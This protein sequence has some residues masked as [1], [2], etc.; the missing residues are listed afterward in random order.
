M[1]RIKHM[2]E[3]NDTLE[4]G[5][6][7]EEPDFVVMQSTIPVEVGGIRLV[8]EGIEHRKGGDAAGQ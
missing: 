5:E 7:T 2:T 3:S 8:P 1:Q 6:W 4:E